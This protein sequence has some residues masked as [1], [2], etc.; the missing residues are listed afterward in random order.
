[1]PEAPEV[2]TVISTLEKQIKECIIEKIEVLYS[3]ILENGN[4]ESW[5]EK[6]EGQSLLE[7]NRIG[8][9]LILSTEDYDWVI[10][11]RMEGKFYIYDELPENLKHIHIIVYLNDGKKLCYHDTRKF[12]RMALYDKTEDKST[13]PSLKNVGYDILD[14]RVTG[15]YFYSQIH[16]KKK[17]LKACLLDQSIMAGIGNI[18]ADE[19]CFAAR[20]D[21]RSR[22][23]RLS[24][25]DCD[26]IV[27][28]SKQII[29]DAMKAGGTTI[30]SYTSSLGVTGLFQLQLNVHTMEECPICR[31]KIVKKVVATRGTYICQHCQKRK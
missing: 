18:Y 19:I 3:K 5:N 29:Q 6:L 17:C 31:D 22:A 25:K 10:H 9:Y 20:L 1:M 13:L 28:Y 21:P 8:K 14:Q 30:R 26:T 27:S 23:A 7:F 12:G 4:E 24:K 15:K 11:L 2:Q 16:S